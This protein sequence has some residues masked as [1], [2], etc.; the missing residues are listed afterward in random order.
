MSR[1]IAFLLLLL[2]SLPRVARAEAPVDAPRAVLEE[3]THDF[4]EVWEGEALRHV[5]RFRNGGSAPLLAKGG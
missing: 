4:G 5:F 3:S 2:A 1:R